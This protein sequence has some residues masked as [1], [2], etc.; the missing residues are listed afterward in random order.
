MRRCLNP[1]TVVLGVSG[2]HM[3]PEPLRMAH[4]NGSRSAG[5]KCAYFSGDTFSPSP[6]ASTQRSWYSLVCRKLPCPLFVRR[7]MYCEGRRTG[8]LRSPARN[9]C[10]HG[11]RAASS[12]DKRFLF[13]TEDASA[14]VASADFNGSGSIAA[15][16]ANA[17][18]R[19][20]TTVRCTFVKVPAP[21]AEA[22]ICSP[23]APSTDSLAGEPLVA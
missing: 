5:F 12:F 22:G 8:P 9:F 11:S 17:L 6:T 13:P 20:T 16:S 15:S 23:L 2:S 4:R 14:N 19:F 7:R 1:R 3:H 21:W 18:D 10:N